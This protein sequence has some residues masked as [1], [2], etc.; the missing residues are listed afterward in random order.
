MFVNAS[1][2][3]VMDMKYLLDSHSKYSQIIKIVAVLVE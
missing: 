1:M 2:H 3:N